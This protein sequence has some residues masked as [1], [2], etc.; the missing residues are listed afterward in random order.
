MRIIYN[1]DEM[2]E[3]ARGWL[4]GG[5]VGF[6]PTRGYL[7]EGHMTLVE[8]AKRECE[9]SVASIFT[10]PL[11]FASDEEFLHYPRDLPRDLQLL[12]VANVDV[13]FIPRVEDLFPPGF[14]TY[15]T[16]AGS[17]AERLEAQ[18]NSRYIRGV[19]T[20]ITK[21][22]Q[23]VR[24]DIAYFGWKDIHQVA[25][26]RQLVRDLNIDVNLRILPT[27]RESD[28]LVRSSRNHFLSAT[29]R[30]EAAAIYPAL[31]AGKA[32]IEQ[33]ERRAAEIKKAIVEQLATKPAITV[34]YVEACQ[35]DTFIPLE[36]VVP[37]TLLII[38]VRAGNQR[39]VDH[40]TWLGD[41]HWLL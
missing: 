14:S 2:T 15:I 26:A 29:E 23:L 13:V 22:L 28:G 11:Q 20:V 12:T 17:F 9:I 10:S 21:L 5:S 40:I 25:I 7:H 39:F 41:D 37:G 27:V 6:V 32:L 35:P 31:M 1:L 8:A 36:E 38:A 4:A 33:G 18:V 3:T 24:P 34:E 19:A 30:Q 16:F